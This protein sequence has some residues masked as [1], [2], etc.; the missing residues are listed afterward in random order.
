MNFQ[1]YAGDATN[2]EPAAGELH[3]SEVVVDDILL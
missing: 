2:M 1:Q 3:S